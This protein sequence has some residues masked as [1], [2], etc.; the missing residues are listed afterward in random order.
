MCEEFGK[1]MN[2]PDD[3]IAIKKIR[4]ELIGFSYE[5]IYRI[6][7][8]NKTFEK[9]GDYLNS[10]LKNSFIF[11]GNFDC[12]YPDIFVF[13]S[14]IYITFEHNQKVYL[15]VIDKE[16]KN[17]IFQKDYGSGTKPKF[18]RNSSNLF[19][20]FLRR[21]SQQFN[22]RN[23]SH[24]DFS[25]S[26]SSVISS[27]PVTDCYTLSLSVDTLSIFYRITNNGVVA[28]RVITYNTTSNSLSSA[29]DS[30]REDSFYQYNKEEVKSSLNLNRFNL[31]TK[32]NFNNKEYQIVWNHF[33]GY[34]IINNE[35][36]VLGKFLGKVS[37]EIDKEGVQF[38]G[39]P[40]FDEQENTFYFP[41]LLA[42]NIRLEDQDEI[43]SPLGL[44]LISFK[45]DRENFLP[46]SETFFNSG[47]LSGSILKQISSNVSEFSFCE[48]PEISSERSQDDTNNQ[49]LEEEVNGEYISDTEEN[50]FNIESGNFSDNIWDFNSIKPLSPDY[51]LSFSG[52]TR[53]NDGNDL[54]ARITGI[55]GLAGLSLDS[56][57]PERSYFRFGT[58]SN[59]GL[60]S[61]RLYIDN[62]DDALGGQVQRPIVL[63]RGDTIIDFGFAEITSRNVG[64]EFTQNS[65]FGTRLL[66]LEQLFPTI[67]QDEILN[68]LSDITIEFYNPLSEFAAGDNLELSSESGFA[69][70]THTRA[71]LDAL[72]NIGGISAQEIPAAETGSEYSL[73]TFR[74]NEAGALL[75][76]ITGSS[77]PPSD[78]ATKF[79]LFGTTIF[80]PRVEFEINAQ[81]V[82]TVIGNERTFQFITTEE[83]IVSEDYNLKIIFS[84]DNRWEVSEDLNFTLNNQEYVA[85][86]INFRKLEDENVVELEVM[87]NVN[88]PARPAEGD[89]YPFYIKT[90]NIGSSPSSDFVFHSV[91]GM[92]AKFRSSSTI[93]DVGFTDEQDE[94]FNI[95]V[96]LGVP[97]SEAVSGE[98]QVVSYIAVYKWV[99]DYGKIHR[100][101][102]SNIITVTVQNQQIGEGASPAVVPLQVENLN[103]TEKE[104]V[105]IEFYRSSSVATSLSNSVFNKIGEIEN[106]KTDANTQFTDSVP[107][108]E[109]KDL[110]IWSGIDQPN[111]NNVLLSFNRRVFTAERDSLIYSDTIVPEREDALAFRLDSVVK[112]EENIISIIP[113]ETSLMVITETKSYI[114]NVGSQPNPT[115]ALLGLE[116][117]S[118]KSV[119]AYPLGFIYQTKQGIYNLSRGTNP[120][121][122]GEDIRS[123][124]KIPIVESSLNTENQEIFLKQENGNVLVFNYLYNK[125][126]ING[127][128][129]RDILVFDDQV[130]KLGL[131]GSLLSNKEIGTA[132]S[133]TI[134]TGNF[135]VSAIQDFISV[136]RVLIMGDFGNWETINVAIAYNQNEAYEDFYELR[137]DSQEEPYGTNNPY[138]ED[139]TQYAP[140]SAER[141]QIL[142][143]P[144]LRKFYSMRIRL[145]ISSKNAKLSNIAFEVYVHGRKNYVAG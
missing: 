16:S 63:K 10:E 12:L 98:N 66:N 48:A 21:D 39:R 127:V 17:I 132:Q 130:L 91:N 105:Q 26:G 102:T 51:V 2:L 144:S 53:G 72:F 34:F 110:F 54:E 33:R 107:Q 143:E 78:F 134:V 113:L 27:V 106:N 35:K 125:W 62:P 42:S 46:K 77:A 8:K 15:S 121:Y 117:I 25:E 114:F 90:N 20:V 109:V 104:N 47:L 55:S 31:W 49:V 5:N 122:V 92:T 112:F 139:A 59:P 96:L 135:N 103:L 57:R 45:I 3:L 7:I 41:A 94:T 70:G 126:S 56:S 141:R 100:S 71:L 9:I 111:S 13:G 85:E 32:F 131:E 97:L 23:L 58:T 14:N 124:D 18:I 83:E 128:S 43:F 93:S 11:Q 52:A 137:G 22:I 64:L 50:N 145:T 136:R 1:I 115:Q 95:E 19:F 108:T 24:V 99:D 129:A 65:N 60:T 76:G 119:I 101:R 81:T 133:S 29:S 6:N 68:N 142:I 84:E 123:I 79:T 69:T 82:S 61:I 67:S 44:T 4:N 75:I 88:P 38:C 86:E 73:T 87:F 116:P 74:I 138:G 36:K 89:S 80:N 37:P 28:N 118:H 30:T 40:Y 140:E 120:T